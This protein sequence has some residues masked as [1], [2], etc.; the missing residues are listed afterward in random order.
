MPG[1]GI[2]SLIKSSPINLKLFQFPPFAPQD[3]ITI[4]NLL[5]HPGLSLSRFI[6]TTAAPKCTWHHLQL[7]LSS[8]RHRQDERVGTLPKIRRM[9][10]DGLH[11]DEDAP[12]AAAKAI[13]R[14]M[15]R[16][17]NN[18]DDGGDSDR[19]EVQARGTYNTPKWAGF[20]HE[21]STAAPCSGESRRSPAAACRLEK[22]SHTKI[23]TP[24]SL[25]WPPVL[26]CLV[27]GRSSCPLRCQ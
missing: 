3:S 15:K 10:L 21:S 2:H 25:D 14:W 5:H 7:P 24:C 18:G 9:G 26:H 16:I 6:Y 19:Q 12:E 22:R 27:A 20:A 13:N 1:M 17:I 11:V 8:S 23:R 4:L